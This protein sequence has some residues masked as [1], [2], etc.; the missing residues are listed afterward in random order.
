MSELT[1]NDVLAAPESE[2]AQTPQGREAV[3]RAAEV[4]LAKHPADCA[5]CVKAGNCA[6]QKVCAVFRPDLPPVAFDGKRERLT[7]G[8]DVVA[9]KC[10]K[11]GRCVGFLKQAGVADPAG[12]M[13]P[14]SCPPFPLSG[15]LPDLCPAGALIDAKA[16]K[17][18]GCAEVV[19]IDS[20]DV[21]DGFGTPVQIEKSPDGSVARIRPVGGGVISDAARYCF[22]GLSRNRLDRPY[23]KIDGRLTECSWTEALAAVASK[24]SQTAPDRIAALFGRYADCETVLAVRDL[25]GLVGAKAVD[26]GTRPLWLDL[27]SRQSWLFNTPFNRIAE[28]DGLL[29]VGANPLWECP[30]AGFALRRNPM[31]KAFV[32]MSEKVEAF[33]AVAGKKP[34]ELREIRDGERAS[35]L[36]N[37]KN[38]MV[39]VG[40]SVLNRADA[41]ALMDLIYGICKKYG[42]IRD[43]WNGFNYLNANT[44]S[45]GALELGAVAE[46]PLRPE[47]AAGSFDFVYL[48]DEDGITPADAGGAFVVYQGIYACPSA[49]TADVVLP[50]LSFMEKR[51]TYVNMRGVAQSTAVVSPPVGQS[52]ESWKIPR[53]L[54]GFLGT[55]PLPYDDLTEIR[56]RLAGENVVFYNRGAA[57]PADDK[58]FGTAGKIDDTPIE[59]TVAGLAKGGART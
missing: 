8:V 33:C 20:V 39:V 58:P 10:V 45:A 11:C 17:R 6:I 21:T 13:P 34:R 36:Q 15:M 28:A 26:A 14:A 2:L 24:M 44:G 25:L 53:A 18:S 19:K 56:D 27:N 12:T 48:V 38:P 32:G 54:S 52:R 5:A 47:I 16:G 7:A 46:N 57:N 3:R 50:S 49:L 22:E 23:V 42:V 59:T 30:P 35:P 55:A 41:P 31:P 51:A 29:V 9:Q 40:D 43:D 37:A 4:F 1:V